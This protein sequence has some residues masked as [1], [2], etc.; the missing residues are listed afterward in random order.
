MRAAPPEHA[1][2][3][4][5]CQVLLTRPASQAEGLASLIKAA[6]GSVMSLP[7]IEI[8]PLSAPDD[9]VKIRSQIM[10]LDQYDSA[11]FISTNAAS[12]GMDWIRQ[13]WPQLPAGLGAFA[14]G[15]STAALLREEV[16]PVSCAEDGV[17][18]EHLLALP[19]LQHVE[20]KRIALFRG[21]GGRELLAE[22][23]R[24]RGAR[25]DYIEVYRRVVPTY[26]RQAVLAQL[27]AMHINTVIITSAQIL[28]SL[29]QLLGL[30]GALRDK[31]ESALLSLLQSLRV[32]VPSQRVMDI[33]RQAGFVHVMDAGAADD[34]AMMSALLQ[35]RQAPELT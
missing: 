5:G 11:I 34:A 15:P 32:I 23:L 9:I 31:P 21:Q 33:A 13:Y 29:L 14:V 25:V 8:E 18:S 30:R 24:E 10:Q 35:C 3:L 26:D 27:V 7:L 17:T 20:G 28:E 1:Q 4:V 12:V 16:W 19:G 22:T 2:T 6:G